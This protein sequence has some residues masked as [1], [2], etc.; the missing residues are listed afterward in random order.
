MQK[1][2]QELHAELYGKYPK[3]LVAVDNVIFGYHDGGLKVLLYPRSFEPAKGN[4]SLLGGFLQTDESSDDAAARIVQITTGLNDLY[5]E[6]VQ[7]FAQPKR[8]ENTRV[9]SIVYYSLIRLAKYDDSLLKQY[10]A[11]WFA[12]NEL[13]DLIFDHAEMIDLS[14]TRLRQ[15]ASIKL[16]GSELLADCFTISQLRRLYEGIYNKEFDAGN[17][18]K[19]V[20]SL[21]VLVRLDKK[22]FDESK[23]GAYYYRYEEDDENDNEKEIIKVINFI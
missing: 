8:E 22:D 6:Q 7:V 4:W 11:E 14:L 23:K 17:F 21:G 19:K 13:P 20:L 12:L 3:Q 2:H 5:M 16:M 18:R 15:K 9:I 1:F 10:G